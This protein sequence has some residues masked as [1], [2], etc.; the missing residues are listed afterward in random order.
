MCRCCYAP[1]INAKQGSRGFCVAARLDIRKKEHADVYDLEVSLGDAGPAE[2]RF[3][4]VELGF[5][6]SGVVTA[7]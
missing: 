4:P 1:L 7:G 2:S 3:K 6:L 5:V